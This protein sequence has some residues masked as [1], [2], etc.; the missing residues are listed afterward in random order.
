MFVCYIYSRMGIK[1]RRTKILA[2]L[3]FLADLSFEYV[4]I[5]EKAQQISDL[6]LNQK[7]KGTLSAMIKEGL[8]EKSDQPGAPK[9][10]LAEKGF[11]QLTLIFPYF[12]FMKDNWDGKWRVLSYEIPE[13]KRDLRDKL[14][15][16]VAGWGLGPWHRS[17]WLTPHPIIEPLKV[18]L[19]YKEEKEFI[20]AFEAEHIFGEREILIE[21]VWKKSEL[22]RRY[23]EVFKKWHVTLS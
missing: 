19:N 1:E 3:F 18:L 9:Y 15:R 14:R 22:E 5:D 6:S 8:I 17:F 4:E 7:T 12:R 16:E 10:K 11:A 20:Q 23:R 2:L 13:K 21:K